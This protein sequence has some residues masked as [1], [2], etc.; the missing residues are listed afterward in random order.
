M[1]VPA[2]GVVALL[3]KEDGNEPAGLVPPCAGEALSQCTAENGTS[4]S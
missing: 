4:Y 2:H 1:N 3:L